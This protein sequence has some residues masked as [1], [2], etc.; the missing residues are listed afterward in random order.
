[1]QGLNRELATGVITIRTGVCLLGR[2]RQH[3]ITT[4]ISS[5]RPP[6]EN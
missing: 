2:L 3:A 4:S 1:M 5:L 6:F